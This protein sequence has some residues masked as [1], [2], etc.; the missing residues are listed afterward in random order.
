LPEI[1]LT[2][3]ELKYMA[4]FQDVTGAVSKDCIIDEENNRIIILVKQGQMGM[5]IGKGGSNVKKLKKILGKEIE[6]VEYDENLEALVK[7][8]MSPARVRSVKL[9]QGNSKKVVYIN[10]EP[11]D[12]G[13]A[14]GKNG[15]NV[16]R[17]KLILKRY[18]DV[19]SVVIV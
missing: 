1:K 14:I 19:D 5:A 13:L 7:N 11:S 16:V 18:M 15:R 12:K 10:V 6:V 2:P 17:A 8:I 9:V 3:D 4:V